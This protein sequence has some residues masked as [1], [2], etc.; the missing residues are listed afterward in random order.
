MTP[1]LGYRYVPELNPLTIVNAGVDQSTI[2]YS[3]FERSL[4]TV[5]NTTESSFL[6]F[7]INNTL[8]LK[9]KSD[10]DTVTG[11]KKVRI[12]DQFSIVGNYNFKKDSM[13]LSNINLNM[14]ISPKDY[15]NFVATASFSHMLGIVFPEELLELMR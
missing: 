12:L 7:A 5:A 9:F 2:S 8:E 1:T 6:T 13:K 15:L 11:F 4:Y 14:R 3:P 10:E